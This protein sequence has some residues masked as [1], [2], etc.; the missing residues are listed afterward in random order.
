M[1]SPRTV[2][3]SPLAPPKVGLEASRERPASVEPSES[4]VVRPNVMLRGGGDRAESEVIEGILEE[5]ERENTFRL[6][7]IK[8]KGEAAEIAA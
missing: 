6:K 3:C 8:E 2:D 1:V 5:M 7:K 4:H